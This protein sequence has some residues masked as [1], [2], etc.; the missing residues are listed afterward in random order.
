M[1]KFECPARSVGFI[2]G[3][4]LP[5]DK[6]TFF[7]EFIE[8]SDTSMRVTQLRSFYAVARHG[9][10]TQAAKA[11]H[12][13]QPTLT[14]QVRALE[15]SYGVELFH[16]HGRGVTLS[17]T[18]RTL[19]AIAQRLFG[20]ESEAV[21]F[22][23]EAGGLR[24]GQIEIGAVGPYHVMEIIGAFRQAYPQLK[25]AVRIGNSEETMQGLLT[26]RTDVAVLAHYAE[27]DR[28]LFVPYR[29]H[30]VVILVPSNHRFAR[31]RSVR[32]AELHDEPMIL[33]ERGSTTR[34]ALEDALRAAG[35]APH[36]TMEIGSREAV[37]EAVILG[38]G[39]AAVSERE[40]VADPRLHKVSISDVDIF[41]HAHVACLKERRH[42]RFVAAFMAVVDTLLGSADSGR[43]PPKKPAPKQP[44]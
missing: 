12:V 9:S 14:T 15:E 43:S 28:L 3:A 2:M 8:K 29:S 38:L 34:K 41:T 5:Y 27:D 40:H 16:R 36:V 11:L 39:L 7:G 44:L 18:G 42:A 10:V 17:S 37:R 6:F 23:K 32:I 33:R 1:G 25:I 13:S 22:L 30:P 4:A 19:F 24:A 26:Y 35:V 21:D 20:N 31:R